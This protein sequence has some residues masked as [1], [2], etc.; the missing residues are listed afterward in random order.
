M[1][2]W[3][4]ICIAILA[5]SI[6]TITSCDPT[7]VQCTR[8]CDRLYYAEEF[9]ADTE[10]DGLETSSGDTK[11]ECRD[12]CHNTWDDSNDDAW[13][14]DRC[15]ACVSDNIGTRP[16]LERV[17]WVIENDCDEKCG[18]GFEFDWNEFACS[19]IA[20]LEYG[21]ESCTPGECVAPN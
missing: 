21:E 2:P 18:S 7:P 9:R 1:K 15:L 13:D 8:L 4:F 19:W 14:I 11:Q 12:A 6:F 3:A 20:K 10:C 17:A 5:M 16:C